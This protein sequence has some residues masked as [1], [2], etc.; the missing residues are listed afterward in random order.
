M[1]VCRRRVLPGA[2]YFWCMNTSVQYRPLAAA[3]N[4]ALAAVIRSTMEEWGV[5]F[6]GTVYFD[7]STDHLYEVFAAEPASCYFTALVNG[8]IAG[9]AGIFPTPGLPQG[10]CE[11]V[12]MY[13]LPSARGLGIGKTLMA[14]CIAA[15]REKGYSRIYLES[16]PELT[17]A[18][19]MYHKTGFVPITGPLGRSGHWGC[20]VW[21]TKDIADL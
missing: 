5:N 1:F 14:K 18:I 11:L 7:E 12:K 19:A 21:M 16:M 9:G 6:P 3:D 15:A 10:T 13:L 2:L 4:A 20:K 17:S 8:Q